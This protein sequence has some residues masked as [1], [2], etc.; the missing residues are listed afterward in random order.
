MQSSMPSCPVLVAIGFVATAA[1]AI[2][3][4]CSTPAPNATVAPAPEPA[5]TPDA[6]ASTARTSQSTEK[7]FVEFKLSKMA[8]PLPGQPGP[9]YPDELRKARIEGEVLAQFVVNPD[10]TVDMSTLKVL[11]ASDPAFVGAVRSMLPSWRWEAAEVSGR[12]VRQLIQ[13]PFQFS[14]AK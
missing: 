10:G 1:I 13:M 3:V 11:K 14:L 12:K 2:I 7:P 4:A 8:T 5:A 6:G 9:R